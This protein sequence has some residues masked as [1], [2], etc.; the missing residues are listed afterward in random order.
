MCS[1]ELL[2]KWK[3][4]VEDFCYTGELE[5]KGKYYYDVEKPDMGF[6]VETASKIII[7]CNVSDEGVKRDLHFQWY[8]N[9]IPTGNRLKINL[10]NGD[11]YIMSEKATGY[12]W[13]ITKDLILTSSGVNEVLRKTLRHGMDDSEFLK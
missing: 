13:K 11:C 5:A 3:D 6:H 4:V 10:S 12:D 2:K 8:S 7:G 9:N 1:L